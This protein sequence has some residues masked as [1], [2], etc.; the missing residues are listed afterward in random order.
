MFDN[1]TPAPVTEVMW[2]KNKFTKHQRVN[3]AFVLKNKVNGKYVK[4]VHNARKT[5]YSDVELK[6]ATPFKFDGLT[7]V[8][9]DMLSI[10]PNLDLEPVMAYRINKT[11][12]KYA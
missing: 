11:I 6:E 1:L 8:V 4:R 10:M 3:F 7:Y 9:S 12:K 2:D 5:I